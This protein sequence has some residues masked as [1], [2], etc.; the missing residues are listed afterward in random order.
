MK[1]REVLLFSLAINIILLASFISADAISVNTTI[2]SDSFTASYNCLKSQIDSRTYASMTIEELASSLWALGYDGAR[3]SAIFNELEKRKSANNCWP[4]GACTLKETS[5]VMLAYSYINKNVDSIKDWLLNQTIPTVD[6][7]WY[8]QIETSNKSECT[9]TYDNISRKISISEEKTISGNPGNCLNPAYNGYWLTVDNKCYDKEIKV[10]CT[11]DFLTSTFYK[12]ISGTT[13][14]VT[15]TTSSASPNGETTQK[16]ESL[17]F[18]QGSSCN[19]EGSLWA[20]SAITKKDSLIRN[21]VLPYLITLSADN[22]NARYLPSAFLYA[23]TG[24]DE[25]F[26]E[27]TNLQNSKG[28]WQTSEATKRYYDTAVALFGLAVHTDSQ[29]FN[30]AKEYLLDPAVKS[31]GCWNNNNIRDTAFILYN[32][33]RK[34]PSG[35]SSSITQCTDYSDQGYSCT[36]ATTCEDDLN[37]SILNNFYCFGSLICC[38]KSEP[39][40]KTCE[41]KGGVSCSFGQECSSQN[42]VPSS[43]SGICCIDGTCRESVPIINACEAATYTCKAICNSAEEEKSLECPENG[44]C[45]AEKEEPAKNYW[46]VWLLILLIILIILAIIYR[47]QLQA[48]IFQIKNKVSKQPIQQQRPMPPQMQ[49]SPRQIIPGR[50]PMPLRPMPPRPALGARPGVPYPRQKELDDTLK[51]L[52]DMSK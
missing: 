43:S 6:L 10:S 4:S 3:Q 13:Y 14:Y 33:D 5:M 41:Q 12:R 15:T 42:T 26:S 38:S 46:W 32:L 24:F 19:Y 35:E 18:K 44:K 30:A 20:I 34:I 37:A 17:C 2:N 1:K 9:I 8:L 27:L 31:Q 7:V 16:I 39:P 11:T 48:W 50:P 45:C 36:D 29:Q 47:N 22:V 23:L 51:K 40:E 21:K 28:Y 52:K 49:F 25:Y